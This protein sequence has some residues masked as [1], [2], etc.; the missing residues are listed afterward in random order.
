[1]ETEEKPRDYAFLMIDY[2]MPNFV[3][4][5][6]KGIKEDELYTEEGNEDYGLEKQCHVTVAACLDN[7]IDVEKLK[8]QLPLSIDCYGAFC[9][10]I[11][12]FENEGFDVLKC[13][14]CCDILNLTHNRIAK[15]FSLHTEF[16]EFNPHLTIAYLK[17][18]MADKYL[19]DTLPSLPHLKP[20]CFH[21]TYHD[22]KN[23]KE[24]S[25]IWEKG[26]ENG[27]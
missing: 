10:N 14:I 12:K 25:V 2:E 24:K 16:K 9:T 6:Q 8:E 21:F 26:S 27:L 22:K 5:I 18:G 11:S 7:D 4:K 20:I 13:S 1:M 17:K 19:Q 15:K 3:K 23:G